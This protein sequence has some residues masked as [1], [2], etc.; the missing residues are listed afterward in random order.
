MNGITF[1]ASGG[2]IA[3][4]VMATVI[5]EKASNKEAQ[6]KSMMAGATGAFNDFKSGMED[7]IEIYEY[8][9]SSS[10]EMVGDLVDRVK[11]QN[12]WDDISVMTEE[13]EIK[14]YVKD[15]KDYGFDDYEDEDEKEMIEDLIDELEDFSEELATYNTIMLSKEGEAIKKIAEIL[16]KV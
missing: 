14:K 3:E 10:L 13:K 9:V 12:L 7:L 4:E 1:S 11:S 15:A 8:Q 5:M 6:A 16:E 2:N